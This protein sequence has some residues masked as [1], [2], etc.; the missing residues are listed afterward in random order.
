MRRE[1]ALNCASQAETPRLEVPSVA[2]ARTRPKLVVWLQ[3]D[4]QATDGSQLSE[5]HT[6]LSRD[7]GKLRSNRTVLHTRWAR[8]FR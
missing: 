4:V 1:S 6:S 2:A 5:T 3:S 7:F 8:D